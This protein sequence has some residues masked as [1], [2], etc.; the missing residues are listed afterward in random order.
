MG[1]LVSS[2]TAMAAFDSQIHKKGLD[3]NRSVIFRDL[4]TEVVGPAATIRAGMLVTRDNSGYIQPA[5]GTDVYGV[6]KWG[7]DTF[8][9]AVK[10]DEAIVLNGTTATNLAR[11]NVSNVTVRSLPNMGGV[12]Y[13]GGAGDD[14]TANTTNGTIA[15]DAASTIPDGGTVYVTYTYALVD[16]D[17]DFDG[18]YWQNQAQDR[19]AYQEGRITIITD[20]AR[21]FTAEWATGVGNADQETGLTYALSGSTSDL[22]CSSTGKFTNVSGT[23][24]VGRVYQLPTASDP[25]MGVTIHGNP[26]V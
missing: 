19:T 15:R 13:V 3:L 2:P 20:W 1:T 24:F 18:R 8:G 4:G 9:T 26:M 7:K 14:F 6:A 25:Y 12:L 5:T 17:Y 16:A 23:E 10:T 11:A 22:F 21:L